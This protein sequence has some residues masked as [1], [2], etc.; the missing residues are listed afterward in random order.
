MR[1]VLQNWL[2]RVE[3]NY[4]FP[5]GAEEE[6]AVLL[7]G[8]PIEEA[9]TFGAVVY[10]F[11]DPLTLEVHAT[12]DTQAEIDLHIDE[13]ARLV[14]EGLAEDRTLGG[15]VCWVECSPPRRNTADEPGIEPTAKA[16]FT[17]TLTYDA[18]HSSG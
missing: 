16:E 17:I 7:D 3:R 5:Q 8:E 4:S 15:T 9:R 14:E 12:R 11:A 18:P 10:R 2:G 1:T 13:V 6:L